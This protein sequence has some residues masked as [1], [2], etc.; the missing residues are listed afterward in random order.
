MKGRPRKP[1]HLH[2]VQGTHRPSRS[3]KNE[4][5]PETVVPSCPSWLDVEAKREWKRIAPEL[6][7]LGLLTRIDRAA[8]AAYCQSYSRWYAAEKLIR[9]NGLVMETPQ[10]YEQQRPEVGIASSALKQMHK[11]LVEF[12]MTP[13]ARS[14]ISA[15]ESQRDTGSPWAKFKQG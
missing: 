7:A 1:T 10:G 3:P 14:R 12:G 6:E 11:F 9:A 8:L 5:K 13:S 15:P 2:V 4:P